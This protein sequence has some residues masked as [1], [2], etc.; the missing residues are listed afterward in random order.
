MAGSHF[1]G[2]TL[3]RAQALQLLFQAEQLS[4][5][6]SVLL[7]EGEYLLSEGP[8]DP[9]AA[10][11]AL[12]TAAMIPELDAII[13]SFSE[14]WSVG[15]MPQ[16]DLCLLR[17]AA[18]EI[19]EV[20]EVADSIAINEAV[21]LAKSFCSDESPRFING[22]LGAIA[23]NVTSVDDFLASTNSSGTDQTKEA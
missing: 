16:V 17:I 23:T 14:N 1:A 2:R 20:D 4:R 6:V 7:E 12:G 3:A 18:Y 8:L 15:R 5:P 13:G 10:D 22:L 19:L 21:E 9:Y 11:L